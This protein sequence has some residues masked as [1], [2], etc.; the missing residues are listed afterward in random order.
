MNRI[1]IFE[2]RKFIQKLNI[3]VFRQF[4]TLPE[5]LLLLE[6]LSLCLKYN[7]T[8]YNIFALLLL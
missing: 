4:C 7:N 6:K 3:A 8:Y 2:H 5:T 1:F